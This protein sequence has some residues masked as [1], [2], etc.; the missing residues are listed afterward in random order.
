MRYLQQIQAVIKLTNHMILIM[1]QSYDKPR[2]ATHINL[3]LNI[4]LTHANC[5]FLTLTTLWSDSA[6]DKWVIFL[7]SQKTGYDISCT[8]SPL[9]TICLKCQ[10]LFS[11]KKKINMSSSEKLTQSVKGKTD[12][13]AYHQS[14]HLT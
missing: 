1:V 8:L 7:F 3:L 14:S 12:F 6:A 9:D 13:N 2:A 5:Y 11:G 4:K 10:I